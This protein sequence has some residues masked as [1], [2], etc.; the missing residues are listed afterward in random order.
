MSLRLNSLPALETIKTTTNKLSGTST[1]VKDALGLTSLHSS[2]LS[3]REKVGMMKTRRMDMSQIKKQVIPFPFAHPS[4]TSR[5][6]TRLLVALSPPFAHTESLHLPR[7]HFAWLSS[8]HSGSRLMK[9][10]KFMAYL[11]Y[12]LRLLTTSFALATQQKDGL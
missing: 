5:L 7:P 4:T 6:P 3:N 12:S 2:H 8:R 10:H 9:P 11:T 1:A